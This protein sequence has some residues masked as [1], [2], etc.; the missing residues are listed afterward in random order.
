MVKIL[1][2]TTIALSRAHKMSSYQI[3]RQALSHWRYLI[4]HAIPL[5]SMSHSRFSITILAH[6]SVW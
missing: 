4:L 5:N 6:Y 3:T 1:N 2:L